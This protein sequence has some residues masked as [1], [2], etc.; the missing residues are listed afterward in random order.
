MSCSER[1]G[2]R[3]VIVLSL[4]VLLGG[5]FRLGPTVLNE[6]QLGFSRALSESEKRQMLLNLVRL[7]YADMPIFLDA[8]QV[9]SGYQLQQN[10]TGG[11]EVFP[12]APTSTFLSGNGSAQ[13]QQSPTFTFQP[14]A[15]D[16]FAQ[17]FL[18]PLSPVDL[19][20]LAE[21]GLPVDV[22]FRLAVQSVGSLENNTAFQQTG[23]AGSPD[24]FVL[25]HDL[26]RLQIANLLGIKLERQPKAELEGKP[27]TPEHVFVTLAVTKKPALAAIESETR[28]LL[29]I[30]P[31]VPEV[32]VIY[33]RSAGS[34][35]QI[36]LLTRS[37][38]GILVSVAFQIEVPLHDV[39]LG[40]TLPTVGFTAMERR[41]VMVI[42][43]GQVPPDNPFTAIQLD[44]QWFWLD[45]NDFDS[46]LAFTM[47][48]IL[49]GLT[50]TGNAP[51]V[52]ITIPAG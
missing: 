3:F 35:K 12:H 23:G 42:H 45:R 5:C 15:G 25:L 50:K 49:L 38:L 14:I 21:G 28:H 37:T 17:S 52:I 22:L 13:L 6:D 48:N 10:I 27:A 4:C 20:A 34:N 2:R 26:R 47:V 39:R 16:R 40:R 9:I 11:V 30:A 46:K 33:G 41:P 36:A 51:G 24:F 43:S 8:T 32:E 31:L 19:L 7:R 1:L 18:R 29:G 44:N